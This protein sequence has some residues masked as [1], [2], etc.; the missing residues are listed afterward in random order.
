VDGK[1]KNGKD[2]EGQSKKIITSITCDHQLCN[3]EMNAI[4]FN[5]ILSFTIF[6]HLFLLSAN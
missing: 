3:F 2:T 5:L 1:K 6:S 4:L